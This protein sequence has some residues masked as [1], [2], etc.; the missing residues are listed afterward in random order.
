VSWLDVCMNLIETG[1]ERKRGWLLEMKV[2]A[3]ERK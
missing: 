1:M 3:V 2:S